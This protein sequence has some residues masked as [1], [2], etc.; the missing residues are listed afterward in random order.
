MEA[1]VRKLV[2]SMQHDPDELIKT[3]AEYDADAKKAQEAAAQQQPA[4]NNNVEIQKMRNDLAYKVHQ[5]KLA[6]MG[7][8]RQFKALLADKEQEVEIMRMAQAKDMTIAQITGQLDAIQRK[9]TADR[10]LMADKLQSA[11]ALPS[12]K[13]AG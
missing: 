2:S 12:G 9:S 8:D 5:D 13:V 4:G 1:T 6:D 3:K 7:A 10:T 11:L